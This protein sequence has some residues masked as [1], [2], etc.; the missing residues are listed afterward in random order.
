MRLDRDEGDHF[1]LAGPADASHPPRLRECGLDMNQYKPPVSRGYIVDR[2]RGLEMV[3]LKIALMVV[4]I[5]ILFF[6]IYFTAIPG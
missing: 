4:M 1:P 2:D 5:A 6:A 3:E